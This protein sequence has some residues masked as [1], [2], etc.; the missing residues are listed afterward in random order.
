MFATDGAPH[1]DNYSAG[2]PVVPHTV[3]CTPGRATGQLIGGKPI[4]FVT[5]NF[6]LHIELQVGRFRKKKGATR[7]RI[8]A[9]VYDT[10]ACGMAECGYSYCCTHDNSQGMALVAYLFGMLYMG[11]MR[12][13]TRQAESWRRWMGLCELSVSA[14][15]YW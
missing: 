3:R 13:K 12:V 1:L 7:T 15:D 5:V 9:S 8:I 2:I 11:Y 14:I 4:Y 6:G 10:L